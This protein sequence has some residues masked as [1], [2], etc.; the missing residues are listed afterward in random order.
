MLDDWVVCQLQV[1]NRIQKL[2]KKT[3][4]EPTDAVEVYFESLDEDKSISQQVLN[5]QVMLTY[6]P[7][8]LCALFF[9]Y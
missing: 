8:S 7:S 4:L 9:T 5:S 3:G 2:R 1:V 6:N